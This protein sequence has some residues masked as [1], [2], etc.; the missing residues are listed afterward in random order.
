M[1]ILFKEVDGHID[2]WMDG[3]RDRQMF[4]YILEKI[5]LINVVKHMT[6]E[7]EKYG[8]PKERRGKATF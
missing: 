8:W 3:W 4:W 1:S 7:S 6:Q 5:I 2:G